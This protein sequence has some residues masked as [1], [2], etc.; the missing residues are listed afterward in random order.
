MLDLSRAMA[1]KKKKNR[2][3]KTCQ[4]NSHKVASDDKAPHNERW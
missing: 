1:A 3:T 4:S 2:A